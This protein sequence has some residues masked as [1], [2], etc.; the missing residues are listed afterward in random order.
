MLSVGCSPTLLR[1]YVHGGIRL[2][3]AGTVGVAEGSAFMA[4]VGITSAVIET[5]AEAPGVTGGVKGA[6]TALETAASPD[7]GATITAP[8]IGGTLG[9]ATD[10]F[11]ETVGT[12]P[13]P[14]PLP[15]VAGEA[16]TTKGTAVGAGAATAQGGIAV[17]IAGAAA[18]DVGATV[19]GKGNADAAA[20]AGVATSGMTTTGSM[21]MGVEGARG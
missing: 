8:A 20:G 9:A 15:L 5:I 10:A 19:R 7:N 11:E 21:A 4:C 13:P 17:A 3:S 2:A 14:P 12:P 1:K 6:I 16:I 18:G